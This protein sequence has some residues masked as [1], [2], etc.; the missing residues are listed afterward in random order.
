[1]IVGRVEV[2]CYHRGFIFAQPRSENPLTATLV[3]D[4]VTLWSRDSMKITVK[5]VKWCKVELLCNGG[6][7]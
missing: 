2:G 6:N 1:M 3:E 5:H 4:L 7:L